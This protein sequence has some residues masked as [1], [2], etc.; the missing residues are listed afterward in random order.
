MRLRFL[1]LLAVALLAAGCD[2]SDDDALRLDAA[3]YTGTWGLVSV[4]DATGDRTG[5]TE[6]FL[7]DL[8]VT[9]TADGTFTLVADFTAIVNQ[10]VRPD[11]TITGDYQASAT[12]KTLVLI[13]DGV[14][15]LFQAD[16][17][18]TNQ[19]ALTAP[20][21]IVTGILGEL[22]FDLQGDVT[23]VVQRR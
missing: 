19:V 1:P 6:P 21:S 15:A 13:S 9:F 5:Q 16:A 7:D 8:R 14:A 22:P 23:L 12:A 4:A 10:T 11:E 20:A 3:F 17:T 2:S 18:V